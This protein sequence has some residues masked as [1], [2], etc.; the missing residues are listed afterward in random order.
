MKRYGFLSVLLILVVVLAACGAPAAT[1]T[2]APA[3]ATATTAPPAATATT[4][5]PAA[6]ATTAPAQPTQGPT[7]SGQVIELQFWHAQSQIQQPVLNSIIDEFNASH[8]GIKVVPTYQGTYSDLYKKVTAAVAAGTPPDLA[9]AYQDQTASYIKLGA[10]VPLDNLMS[11]PQ[12]GFSAQDLQDI[13]PSFIDHYPLYN[14]QVYSI[15]FMRS[16]DVMYYDQ[17]MLT[18]AGLSGP[19]QT[20]D[21]FLSACSAISNPPNTFCYE[22]NPDASTFAYWVFTRG[23][24]LISQDAKTVTF[25]SAAGLD[26][27]QLIATLFQK[28]QAY[29]IGTAY[30]DQTDFALGK[31]AFTFGS[32]AGLPYYAQAVDQG[33]VVKNWNISA[34]PHSTSTPAVELYGPSVTV[35]KTT[36][37]KER[38]A[39]TFIKW[40]MGNAPNAEWCEA[41]QYFPARQSTQNQMS[42]FISAHPM[43][44]QALGWVQYGHTEPALAA[45]TAI[46]TYITDAMTAVA[47]G[48][49]T[50]QEAMNTLVQKSNALLAQQ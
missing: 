24:T 18:A 3:A 48:T 11:D 39:F 30:Q 9:I 37:E 32:T 27:L 46:R 38:A 49:Q 2:P 36:T 7:P 21:D 40:M 34:G 17:D 42:D 16:M 1:A 47:D 12:I 29:L 4:A 45:W 44:G 8:P 43:Y 22:L 35:F 13:F 14:D 50:P 5:P 41:T 33:G 25:D 23:G 26:S 31:I 6:T 20:W 28:N 15:A 19:P 10:V